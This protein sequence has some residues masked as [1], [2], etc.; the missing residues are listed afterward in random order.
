[1]R[2]LGLTNLYPP[3]AR[4]G[5]GEICADVMAGLAAR[6][7]SVTML[8]SSEAVDAGL[9]VRGVVDGV[10]VRRELG[11]VLAAWRKP[12]RGLRA[13]QRDDAV[14]RAALAEGVD[15][16]IVWHMRGV[17]KTSL[18]LIH[19][20]G[21]PVL[22]QLHDRWVV[23]ERPGPWL[24]PW[25]EIDRFGGRAL[26]ELAGVAAGRALKAEIR[27]PR[28]ERDGIVCFVSEWLEGEYARLGWHAQ[29]A[30]VVNC[31]V[32]LER[33]G[34]R[35]A[36]HETPPR[37]L[38]FAGRIERRKGIEVLL[39]ALAKTRGELTLTIAGPPE[40]PDYAAR[41]RLLGEE[42]GIADRVTWIGE[43]PRDQMPGLLAEHDVLVL[44][45][46]DVEAYALGLLEAL[47]AGTLVVTSAVGGPREYLVDGQN[48]LVFEP[49]DVDGLVAALD[50]LS[51]AATVERLRR[52]AKE[53]SERFALPHIIDRVEDLITTALPRSAI[54]AR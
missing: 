44:P 16:A 3:A 17:A 26:R 49:G 29:R 5:Y 46:V 8:V 11:Y 22:Y 34:G 21:I 50:K 52:G 24:R 2:L 31:G 18:R 32:D 39:R 27:A 47:A 7:H 41:M 12:L 20:S 48:S 13:A 37:R 4:G 14:V 43:K 28:I 23:Y 1:M 35:T 53:T 10:E 36:N 33:F 40:N 51:D 30:E 45:S 38:L 54:E 25:A 19:D 42:L 15:A 9:P 6:G